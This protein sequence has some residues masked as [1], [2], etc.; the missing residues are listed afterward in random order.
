MDTTDPDIVFDNDGVCSHCHR[1]DRVSMQRLIPTEQ[2]TARLEALVSEIKA[3]GAG[4]DYDC[5]IGVSGGVDSTYVAYVVKN[6]GLRPL[7]IHL[8][9]G[10]NSELAV[11]NIQKTLDVLG[12]DLHTHV[13]D[14]EEFR[15]L[16]LSFLKAST[17]DGEVP[18]DHAI[19]ALLYE[20]AN[21]Y[22]LKYVI[23]GTNIVSEA[24]LPEKWGYG[25]FDWR[26]VSD[27]HRRFGST[28]L[29]TYPHFSLARLF[30]YVFFRK[31]RLISILNY[32]DY[33]KKEA[34]DVL[35]G[36]LGW[37]YYGGKHYESIYT[38]FYQAYWLLRKFNIDKRKAHYSNLILSGQMTR[39]EALRGLEEPVYP[40]N[41]LIEDRDYATKKLRQTPDSMEAMMQAPNKTFL[42]YRT[43]HSL[44]EKAKTL[45]NATRRYIG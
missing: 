5:V 22:G 10:W 17:P 44:F 3:A 16:Q 45:V 30:Y 14:W 28:K 23:T 29:A 20:M 11:A 6:L 36:K 8:D 19:F 34:M 38:R 18:T 1:Y 15:D 2:R 32:I 25:Y 26:Y 31:I 42:D 37:V 35:Q 27:V 12:I 13:I 39:D 40:E 21:K 33:E 41:L 4:K 7:A 43:S 24:I 9:N